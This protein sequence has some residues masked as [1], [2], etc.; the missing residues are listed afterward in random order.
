MTEMVINDKRYFGYR[1][2]DV[3]NIL[4]MERDH[5]MSDNG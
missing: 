2:C 3:F 5:S 1:E 4:R